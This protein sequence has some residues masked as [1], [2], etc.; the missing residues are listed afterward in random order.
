M[1][2]KSIKDRRWNL[3]GEIGKPYGVIPVVNNVFSNILSVVLFVGIFHLVIDPSFLAFMTN[4]PHLHCLADSCYYLS[5]FH[6]RAL[7]LFY[8]FVLNGTVLSDRNRAITKYEIHCNSWLLIL[9]VKQQT[10]VV[11]NDII[12]RRREKIWR[13][14]RAGDSVYH[15]FKTKTSLK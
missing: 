5:Y 9:H 1:E 14:L 13:I 12:L 10:I 11:T 8:N 6:S 7:L 2:K 4:L 3:N 15:I